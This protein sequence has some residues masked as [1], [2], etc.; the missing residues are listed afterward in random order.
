MLTSAPALLNIHFQVGSLILAD[1]VPS[2]MVFTDKDLSPYDLRLC[3]CRSIVNAV[4]LALQTGSSDTGLPSVLLLDPYPDHMANALIRTGSSLFQLYNTQMVTHE[5][6]KHMFSV[7]IAGLE[8]LAEISHTASAG[9]SILKQKFLE[10]GIG[11]VGAL[12][13]D[14]FYHSVFS[15]T[16]AV[17]RDLFDAGVVKEL[18]QQASDPSLVDKTVEQN[19]SNIYMSSFLFEDI[20]PNELDFISHD[21][22]FDVR[23]LQYTPLIF[24]ECHQDCFGELKAI[25]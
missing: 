16:S 14:A 17:D 4:N 18:E 24:T 25:S 7:V 1:A 19:E 12:Q 2:S 6:L 23:I 10:S 20:Q 21:W 3:A 22:T 5:Q 8:I 13:N 9:S 15:V 11:Q